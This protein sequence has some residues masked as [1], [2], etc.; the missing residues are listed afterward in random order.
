MHKYALYTAYS[1]SCFFKIQ[2]NFHY[3]PPPDP[4]H[5]VEKTNQTSSEISTHSSNSANTKNTE[6]PN[7][8]KQSIEENDHENPDNKEPI[9]NAESEEK[10]IN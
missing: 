3:K 9:I 6:V 2:E 4:I 8:D 7:S 10:P 1:F 5:P